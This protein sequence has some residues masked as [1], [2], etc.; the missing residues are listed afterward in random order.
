M[1]TK[2]SMVTNG[3]QEQVFSILEMDPGAISYATG[4]ASQW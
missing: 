4:L 3:T 1:A 2:F